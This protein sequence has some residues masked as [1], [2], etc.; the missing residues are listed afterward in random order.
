MIGLKVVLLVLSI[1]LYVVMMSIMI[2]F[3]RDKPKN[4]II[5]SVV[6]LF[7]QIVGYIIYIFI[8][9]RIIKKHILMLKKKEEDEIYN[10][11]VLSKLKNRK[12]QADN[13]IFKFN[14]MAFN[15]N[16]TNNNEYEIIASHKKF[17]QD[18]IKE[19]KE[20]KNHIIFELTQ[21]DYAEFEGMIKILSEK[22][23]NNVIVKVVYNT[24]ISR[25]LKSEL[26]EAGIKVYRFGKYNTAG[27]IHSNFRNIIVIDGRV[28]YFANLH[29]G[30]SQRKED[31]EVLNAYIK[32][33]G[34]VVQ[35]INLATRQDVVF[36]SGKFMDYYADEKEKVTNF[37]QIQFVSNDVDTSIEL[38]IIK[39]ICSAKKSV[40]LQLNEFIPTESV[41][42]LLRFAINSN[43]DVRLMI[44]L[45]TN[46]RSKYYASRAYAKEL[47]LM[48]ANVYLYDGF[49]KFNAI[50]IDSEYV[51]YGSF[52]MDREH[53]NTS[54]QNAILVK[55]EKFV[56]SFNKFFD[57]GINNS[58]RVSNAKLMLTSEKFFKN[59]V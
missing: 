19:I 34:D 22:V 5:W 49:I 1:L 33:K 8:R 53:I 54:L 2:I 17:K 48:G 21:T 51:I 37:S 50:T 6:F 59:F 31:V 27:R 7:T 41:L 25:K 12:T 36:A 45:K 4:I 30:K 16:P 32:L 35:E 20:S 47:A 13:E 55:D 52:I 23:K 18:L 44:P 11:L 14:Q 58:Y 43:I 39:A 28:A 15:S 56:E 38:M 26:K 24:K 3:E 29:V 9:Q 42:A 10:N 57:S 46:G 40:Q